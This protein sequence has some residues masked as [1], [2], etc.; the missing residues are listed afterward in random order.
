MKENFSFVFD[1]HKNQIK[2]LYNYINSYFRFV[3]IKHFRLQVHKHLPH[4][5]G[6]IKVYF[7]S[8]F[9]NQKKNMCALFLMFFSLLFRDTF[10]FLYMC[11]CLYCSSFI[12]PLL[13]L[14]FFFI[15]ALLVVVHFLF[16]TFQQCKDLV[17]LWL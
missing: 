4:Q 11:I 2:N 6:V 1:T 16:L 9:V 8:L 15:V 5:N 3:N 7:N 14:M 10:F 13:Y 12:I 17:F